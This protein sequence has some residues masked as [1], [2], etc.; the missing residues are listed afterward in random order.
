MRNNLPYWSALAIWAGMNGVASIARTLY[1]RKLIQ[2]DAKKFFKESYLRSALVVAIS[3]P[4]PLYY[5]HKSDADIF[6]LIIFMVMFYVLY[7]VSAWLLG[8]NQ[9]E[10]G[11]V[12][13]TIQ[14]KIFHK[15]K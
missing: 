5:A 12:V 9:I 13:K 11:F 7:A 8:L 3:T 2:L 6:S 10:R 4:L 1:M 15:H 14:D